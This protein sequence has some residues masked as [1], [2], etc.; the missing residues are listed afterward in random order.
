L[1]FASLSPK[2][3]AGGGGSTGDAGAD[4]ETITGTVGADFGVGP[5]M[6]VGASSKSAAVAAGLPS[7]CSPDAAAGGGAIASDA[8]VWSAVAV[9]GGGVMPSE[10]PV[11]SAVA[12]AGGGAMP[13]EA[14]VRS[15][16][17]EAGGGTTG[18]AAAEALDD[19]GGSGKA[20]PWTVT[21][22]GC[23]GRGA[24]KAERPGLDMPGSGAGIA[25]LLADAGGAG[26][27]PSAAETE[28]AAG[29]S[30]GSE[31]CAELA[32]GR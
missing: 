32:E 15:A 10:A 20:N 19:E 14:P 11:W 17:E 13:S 5:T 23:G 7:A 12:V 4:G 1:V 16:V 22:A 2:S 21:L 30:P 8:P 31:S 29:R 24:A 25:G 27:T 9:A 26:G 28:G 18:A 3:E 6:R